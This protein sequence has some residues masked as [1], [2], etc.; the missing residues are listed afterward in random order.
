SV[1]SGNNW[2]EISIGIAGQDVRALLVDPNDPSVVYAAS[3]GSV[4]DPGGVYRSNDAG[5]S[6]NSISIGLPADAAT[7]LALDPTDPSRL[8]AGTTASVWELTQLPD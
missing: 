5:L 8:L 2:A 4:A 7:A 6:W 3:G 1:D